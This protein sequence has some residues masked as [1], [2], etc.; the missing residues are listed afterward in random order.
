M[1]KVFIIAV[2]AIAYFYISN[3][4]YF[5]TPVMAS[6]SRAENIKKI[7]KYE[8]KDLFARSKRTS[9]LAVKDYY[10][11]VEVYIDTC[12]ICKQLEAGFLPFIKKRNDVVI[13]K[14]HFPESGMS[15]DFNSPQEAEDLARRINLYNFNYA[16]VKNGI[17]NMTSCGT[18]HIEIYGPDKQL[19]ATDKCGKKNDKSGLAFLR[20][21]MRAEGV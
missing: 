17:F 3:E 21:W 10:T 11:I 19:V 4:K 2:V 16:V 5:V 6:G 1:K 20:K 14:L 15:I 13:R 18:P 8:Y 7:R 9:S 12:S